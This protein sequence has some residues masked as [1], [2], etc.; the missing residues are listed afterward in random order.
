MKPMKSKKYLI[1]DTEL[2]SYQYGNSSGEYIYTS[3]E[4]FKI[5]IIYI[6][7]KTKENNCGLRHL[8]NSF[9]EKKLLTKLIMSRCEISLLW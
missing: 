4:N 9:Q 7:G 8:Q 6:M 5:S 2:A 3:E 1:K